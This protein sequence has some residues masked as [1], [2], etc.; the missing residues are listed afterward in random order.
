M[1]KKVISIVLA[2]L[3]V[4]SIFSTAFAAEHVKNP[5]T[6][7]YASI[8]NQSTLDPHYAY[9]ADSMSIIHNVVEGLIAYKGSKIDEF[10]PLLSTKVPSKENGLLSEDGTEYTFVIREGVEFSNG[11]KL[12]PEDV[13]Y[14]AMRAIVLD[15]TGGPIWML[16][17]PLFGVRSLDEVTEKV[18]GVK[19]ANNLNDEQAKKVY[20]AIDEKITIDGNKVTFHLDSPYPPFLNVMAHGNYPG[21]ILDKEWSIEQGAWPGTPETIAKHHDPSTNE[22][23]LQDKLMGTGPFILEEWDNGNRVIFRRNDDYWREPANFEKAI[24]KN[25]DEWSTRK[26]M[27]MRGDVDISYV[28]KQYRNQLANDDRFKVYNNQSLLGTFMTF[29]WDLNTQGNDYIGSGKLDGNGIPH[30]FFSDKDVRKAFSY[31]FNYKAFINQIRMGEAI[32]L[33]GP[34]VKPLLG[35][36]DNS[37]NYNHNMQKAKEHFKKAFDGKVWDRGFEMT[38]LYNTG[39]PARK[40]AC[41]ILKTYVEQINPK[42]NVKVRSLQWSTYLDRSSRNYLPISVNNWMADY[43]DPHNFVKPILGAGSYYGERR[44]EAYNE[45]VKESGLQELIIKGMDT[46]NTEEREKIY[47]EIQKI[48]MDNAIDI[49]LDQSMSAH[50]E[51]SYMEGYYH[52]PMRPGIYFYMYDKPGGY[53]N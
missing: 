46:T 17:E 47:T 22:D 32:P 51:R 39:N 10:K 25:I 40:A 7:S 45:W 24:I 35:Y 29:N 44:G 41:D 3:V 36:D 27:F 13:K 52:N 43:P 15:R 2:L 31:A 53:G 23:P 6:I 4:T 28:P 38:I 12:T 50:V 18:V 19:E 21:M 30:D 11:N 1:S 9:D 14:S 49:W 48:A 5:N 34:I 26:L 33:R 37:M 16:I 20:D 8:G 42:F